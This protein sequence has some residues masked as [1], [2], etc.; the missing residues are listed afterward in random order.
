MWYPNSL[1]PRLEG[2]TVA[3]RDSWETGGLPAS[4]SLG[5]TSRDSMIMFPCG[6]D[7]KRPPQEGQG[8]YQ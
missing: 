4:L 2:G 3:S 5:L 1:D 8:S 6:L 7:H